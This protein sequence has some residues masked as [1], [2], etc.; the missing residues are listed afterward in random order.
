M[1]ESGVLL[2]EL[3]NVQMKRENKD[4]YVFLKQFLSRTVLGENVL[5]TT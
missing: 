3:K 4:F 1:Y 2:A 5:R